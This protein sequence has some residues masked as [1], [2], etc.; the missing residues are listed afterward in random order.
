MGLNNKVN[1]IGLLFASTDET[2][3]IAL[4][5]QELFGSWGM[6]TWFCRSICVLFTNLDRSLQEWLVGEGCDG[7]D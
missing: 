1:F 3:L 5:N 6:I 7:P 2:H 4:G